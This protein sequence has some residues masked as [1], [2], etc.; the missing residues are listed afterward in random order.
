M[1][2]ENGGSAINSTER[3]YE[4]VIYV[5]HEFDVQMRKSIED[6][7]RSNKKISI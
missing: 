5:E 1:Q 6:N 2:N 4:S 7:F 3:N